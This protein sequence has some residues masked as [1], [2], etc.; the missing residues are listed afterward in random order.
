[1]S[2]ILLFDDREE[3]RSAI[4]KRLSK[5][6]ADQAQTEL[7]NG[8]AG[9]EEGVT[10]E[11]HI[12]RQLRDGHTV[13]PIGLIACDK[14]LGMYESFPGLSA[15]AISIVARNLGIPFCQYSQHP[16]ANQREIARFEALKQWDSEEITL[17][18]TNSEEW[19]EEIA[20]LW[21]GFESVRS[22][23][24]AIANDKPKPAAALAEIMGRK[25]AE[26][27][28]SLYGSGDQSIM[29][30][31][32]AFLDKSDPNS[33]NERMP[34]VLGTWLQLS[35]L[36]FPGLLVNETAAASYLNVAMDDFAKP[37]IQE[38]FKDAVYS[39]PFSELLQW[40]WRDDLERLLLEGNAQDGKEFLNAQD[41]EVE[42]CLDEQT[43]ERAGFY[44]MITQVPVSRA[45]SKG[46]I[47]WFPSGA[48]LSR[49]RSDEF[50]EI[51]SLVSM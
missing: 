7:F 32:F 49:I 1:M 51:T 38:H 14:E 44:C 26:T 21:A 45:N 40:W 41:A 33:M 28:I 37:G 43:G 8:G 15:N 19:A 50:E 23:Y 35:I 10:Y 11:Q 36:R 9:P 27:R 47:N 4:H 48:D 5:L 29:T 42:P 17:I 12:E 46:N 24:A 3:N 16:K 20:K 31:V 13:N 6:V 25:D 39:G 34:R 22:K 18:G 30:E 2:Q